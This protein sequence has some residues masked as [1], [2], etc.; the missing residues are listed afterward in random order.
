MRYVGLAAAVAVLFL[1]ACGAGT[2]AKQ[3]TDPVSANDPSPTTLPQST[4]TTTNADTARADTASA[5]AAV[6]RTNDLPASWSA[7][8][9]TDTDSP[10]VD[11][12]VADCLHVPMRLVRTDDFPHAYSSDFTAEAG[13]LIQG[14]VTMF[15]TLADARAEMAVLE[16]PNVPSCA[17][18]S[19]DTY[20]GR[21]AITTRG[22]SLT[23]PAVGDDQ[24]AHR[25]S[26]TTDGVTLG[27]V[28]SLFTRR[29]RAVVQIVYAQGGTPPDIAFE[30]GLL[31]KMYDRLSA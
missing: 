7:R 27:Y 26:T 8:T 24:A 22:A 4:T 19:V 5:A 6:L 13:T 18:S 9:H 2:S 31:K 10:S 12:F 3:A 15:P 16:K 11:E 29:G 20:L 17:A 21:P 30:S 28:D 14:E 23:V 25:L 1:G